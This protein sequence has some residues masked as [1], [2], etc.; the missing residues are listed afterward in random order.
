MKYFLLICLTIFNTATN[1]GKPWP[2]HL[3]A[4]KYSYLVKDSMVIRHGLPMLRML[5]DSVNKSI[6]IDYA[7]ASIKFPDTLYKFDSVMD[8]PDGGDSE[9]VFVKNH[10]TPQRFLIYFDRR[11]EFPYGYRMLFVG[12]GNLSCYY[13]LKEF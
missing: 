13:D 4:V 5:H 11:Q 2:T 8:C 9:K 3:T 10:R 12:K 6:E 1:H 7:A